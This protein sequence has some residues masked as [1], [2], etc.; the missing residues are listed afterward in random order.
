MVGENAKAVVKLQGRMKLKGFYAGYY[1]NSK[2]VERRLSE[3][4]KL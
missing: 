2:E 4:I 3:V 1:N